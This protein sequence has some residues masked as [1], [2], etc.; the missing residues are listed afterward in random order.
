MKMALFLLL[1]L[2]VGACNKAPTE[3]ALDLSAALGGQAEQGFSR[4]TE[5]RVFQ[6]P[7]DHAAHPGFRTEW[8]YVT[9]NLTDESNNRY[10]YQ[11]TLFRIALSPKPSVSNSNW[12]TNQVWMAHV[13]LTDV[14]ANSH[15]HEQ[16]LARGAVGLAG[17]TDQPFRVWLEDWQIIGREQGAFPWKIDLQTKQFGLKLQLSPHK[18]VVLQGDNGLSQKSSQ[19]GNASYYYSFTRLQ[20]QGEIIKNSQHIK[21]N[22]WSWLDREWSTSALGAD[23]AGW[24]WFSLQLFD[25]HDLMFYRLRKKNGE[26]DIHSA[27]K[28]VMPGGESQPL[29]ANDVVMQP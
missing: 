21:V 25:Q 12:A 17:Q 1:G 7:Q 3:T 4:A 16:R 11:V 26:M 19:A 8:W 18:P 10:G 9:G 14:S 5:P 24:D 22:G 20:T 23:Q 28:W 13:A 6:F 27:G 29:V 2:L 15:W